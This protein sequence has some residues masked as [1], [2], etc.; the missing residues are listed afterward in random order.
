MADVRVG[1][2]ALFLA[3]KRRFMVGGWMPGGFGGGRFGRLVA[4][5]ETER[6]WCGFDLIWSLQSSFFCFPIETDIY[7]RLFVCERR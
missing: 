1:L 6:L 5:I 7:R 3:P 4:A 2:G